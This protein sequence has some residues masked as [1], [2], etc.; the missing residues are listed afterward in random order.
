[1]EKL[2]N[3][4]RTI[5]ILLFIS[6]FS[7]LLSFW[8]DYNGNV[9]N[10]IIAYAIPILFWGGM[11]LAYVMLYQFNKQRIKNAEAEKTLNNNSER[12]HN[13]IMRPTRFMPGALRI[14]S[15]KY[16]TIFDFLSI[17][18]LILVIVLSFIPN[19]NQVI[20]IVCLS[21]LVF[22]LQMHCLLNGVNFTYILLKRR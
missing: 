22:S 1:M 9:L 3:K 2:N 19:V 6:S 12:T 21:V 15:N 11:I 14:I 5:I 20:V 16:A 17:I 10:I 8:G 18:F 7:L 4:M 13:R